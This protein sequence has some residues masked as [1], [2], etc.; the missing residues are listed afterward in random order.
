MSA[1]GFAGEKFY[2]VRYYAHG[3][4][5]GG[6]SESSPAPMTDADCFAIPEGTLV[7]K[8]YVIIDTA[9]S[10]TTAIDVGDDDDPNGFV[11]TGDLTL[12]T[13]GLYGYVSTG[14][15]L[16]SGAAKY[17]AASGKE[18]KVDFTG[19]STAGALRVVV[20]GRYLGR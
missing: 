7:E 3:A 5:G 11:V 13:P 17:Y 14:A 10:G 2:V 18:V 8:A 4:T 20:E 6:E 16:A 9:V 15:Y 1:L 12:G 19:T